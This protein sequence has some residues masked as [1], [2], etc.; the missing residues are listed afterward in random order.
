[1]RISM[2]TPV[3]T[4]EAIADLDTSAVPRPVGA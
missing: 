1:M 3:T 4:I 2:V